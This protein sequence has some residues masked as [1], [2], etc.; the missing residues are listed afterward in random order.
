MAPG[1]ARSISRPVAEAVLVVM[2]GLAFL[3]SPAR[4]SILS[5]AEVLDRTGRSITDWGNEWWQRAF[6]GPDQLG[7]VGGPVFFAEGSSGGS[8]RF[9]Y[10]IPGGQF[11]LLPVATYIWTFFDPCADAMCAERIINTNFIDEIT[12]P[13]ARIDG[14]RVSRA[15]LASHV[16]RVDGGAIPF[17]VDTGIPESGDPTQYDGIVDALQGGYWLM[18]APL[19]PGRHRI[20]FGATVPELDPDTGEPWTNPDTGETT[21]DLRTRLRIKATPV[22]EPSTYLLLSLGLAVLAFTRRSRKAFS[23]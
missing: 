1:I 7:D 22:P 12:R 4:A 16:V 8:V 11:V 9:D 17:Q 13:F 23:A 19:A 15:E 3:A 2:V 10:T 20:S 5:T 18:L 21:I 14:V 6:L